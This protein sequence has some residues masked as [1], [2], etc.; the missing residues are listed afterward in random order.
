MDFFA[1]IGIMVLF[2]KKD[3]IIYRM[4]FFDAPIERFKSRPSK[5]CS[6]FVS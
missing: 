1:N 6:T 4:L 2:G 5:S 3:E